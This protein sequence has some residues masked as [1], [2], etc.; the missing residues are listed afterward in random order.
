MHSYSHFFIGEMC[1]W[2]TGFV[3]ELTLQATEDE[4]WTLASQCMKSAFVY[5]RTV[6]SP[7]ANALSDPNKVS[8]CTTYMWCLLESHRL[9]REFLDASFRN[10]PCIAPVITLHLFRS[11]VTKT[12]F[13]EAIKRLEG[14]LNA[15]EKNGPS[16]PAAKGGKTKA[17]TTMEE[18]KE[19]TLTKT[20]K[21]PG[22]V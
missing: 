15:L 11:Q 19:G 4:A 7:A 18:R 5:L 10:H 3:Q 8:R 16:K 14:C 17:G 6:C 21:H 1:T 2:V 13:S 9:M 12:A 20:D 22:L